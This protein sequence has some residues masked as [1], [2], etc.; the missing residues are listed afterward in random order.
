[1]KPDIFNT[2]V[3]IEID[4]NTIPPPPHKQKKKNNITW[5]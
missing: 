3:T 5:F 2:P 4:Q 1:M